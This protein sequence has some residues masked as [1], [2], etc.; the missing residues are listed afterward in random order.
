MQVFTED[1]TSDLADKLFEEFNSLSVVLGT[2][3]QHFLDDQALK[4]YHKVHTV[5]SLI[6]AH[7]HA[8]AKETV[9]AGMQ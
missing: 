2:P 6:F 8:K 1:A 5:E 3:A 9:V 7:L 4:Q